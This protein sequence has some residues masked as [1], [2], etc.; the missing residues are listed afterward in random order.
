[1]I[2]TPII[3]QSSGKVHAKAAAAYE[4]AQGRVKQCREK[5]KQTNM[6]KLMELEEE[7]DAA[8]KSA[9]LTTINRSSIVKRAQEQ[10]K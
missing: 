7:R 8:N 9:E 6:I 2:L 1:M 4:N 3:F 5:G 10:L